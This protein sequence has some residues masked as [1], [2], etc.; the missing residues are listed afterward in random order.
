MKMCTVYKRKKHTMN[1]NDH[2]MNFTN[3][4]KLETE[5]EYA[6]YSMNLTGL[7]F[8]CAVA[9]FWPFVFACDV[10]KLISYILSFFATKTTHRL[11]RLGLLAF[12]HTSEMSTRSLSI[13]VRTKPVTRS[14]LQKKNPEITDTKSAQRFNCQTSVV[15]SF[16]LC[17]DCSW[18][19]VWRKQHDT[20]W[21]YTISYFDTRS[22]DDGSQL[23]LSHGT[24]NKKNRKTRNRNYN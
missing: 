21:Y 10:Y 22:K 8:R 17:S 15:G 13:T 9:R 11:L 19:F 12:R 1:W 2:K 6:A 14:V 3:Q 4:W 20:I 18:W 7:D 23:N 5:L 24:K 16:D